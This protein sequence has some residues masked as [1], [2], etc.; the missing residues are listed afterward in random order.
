M[1][2][3]IQLATVILDL[4]LI[5]VEVF[6][7]LAQSIGRARLAF[8]VENASPAPGSFAIEI[9]VKGCTQRR[10]NIL[11]RNPSVRSVANGNIVSEV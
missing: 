11:R 10:Y 3:M 4:V 9:E 6:E 5:G 2:N 8:C 7:N 1:M